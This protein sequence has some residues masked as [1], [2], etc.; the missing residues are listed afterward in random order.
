VRFSI[1]VPATLWFDRPQNFCRCAQW[2]F[3]FVAPS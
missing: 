1:R 2:T 3:D